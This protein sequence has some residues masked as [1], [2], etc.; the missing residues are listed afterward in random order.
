MTAHRLPRD[1]P[2]IERN[3]VRMVVRDRAGRVLLF[4][5]REITVPE[6]GAWWELPGGGIESGEDPAAAAMRE[7]HEETGLLVSRAQI[8]EPRWWRTAAFRHRHVRHLQHEVVMVVQLDAL[9]PAIDVSNR[10][11]YEQEDYLDQ[12]WWPPAEIVRST[13]RFYPGRLRQLL[14]RLLDGEAI[15][16]PF[17]LWS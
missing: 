5:T 1:L 2:V 8:G 10:L 7:L 14:P 12:R 13:Q 17:E 3:A 15:D 9:T 11:D 16:E 4:H 6:L